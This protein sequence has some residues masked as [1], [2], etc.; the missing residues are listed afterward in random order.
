MSMFR[1]LVGVITHG[2]NALLFPKR[3]WFNCPCI[4]IPTQFACGDLIVSPYSSVHQLQ[5]SILS[6]IEA[7][8]LDLPTLLSSELCI[9]QKP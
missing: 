3:Y 8:L 7:V 6:E 4:Y 5:D 2:H 9:H 1:D